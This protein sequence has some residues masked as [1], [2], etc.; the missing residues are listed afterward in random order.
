M[1]VLRCS[2]IFLT[3]LLFTVVLNS[4]NGD[5]GL[6]K[7][8]CSIVVAKSLDV[9]HY[10]TRNSGPTRR[11]TR[12]ALLPPS[13]KCMAGL[14][15]AN[16]TL[17]ATYFV[18]LA[19][20]IQQNP[21]PA[22]NYPCSLGRS[23]ETCAVPTV[24]CGLCAKTVRKNQSR[25]SCTSCLKI[26]HLRCY[27]SDFSESLCNLCY[28]SNSDGQDKSDQMRPEVLQ[29]YIPDLNEFSSRKGLK[30]L[31]Q[32]IRGLLTNKHSICQILD[33]LKNLHI[34]SLSET[35]LSADDEVQAQI[36]GYAY[37]G[38]ARTSGQGGGVG[39]YIPSSVP[40][41]RRTDL[42]ADDIECI[43]IEILFPKTKSFLIGIIYRPPDS[44][45]HLCA[46]FN[47][48]FESMLST[49]SSEDKECILTGDINCNYLVPADHKEIKSIL[50]S[51][52]LKQLI[53]T[54]TRIT[55]ESKTLI[56]I[57]CSNEP[58]KINHV[59]VIPAGL[60]DHELICCSR[61]VNNVKHHPRIITCRNFANY[62]AKLFCEELN[63]MNF[64]QV[65]SS[66]CVN[67][68]WNV[69]KNILQQCIDKHAPLIEKK[70]KGRLCPWLTQEVKRE[71]NLRD[72]LLR[73][74]RRTNCELDWSSYK[75]QRNRVTGLI[76]KCKSKYHQDILRDSADSPDKFWCAIKKLYPTKLPSEQGSA[77]QI[78]G[79]KSTDK[80]FISNGFC[81]FFTNA[82]INL[83]RKSFLLRDFVWCKNGTKPPLSKEKFIFRAVKEADI[84][85]ELKKLKRKKATGLDNLS[86][87]LLKDAAE[88]ITKPL[89]FIINLSLAT[90]V[91]PTDWKVAKVIPLFKSGSTAEIDNYRPISILPTLSKIL[92]RVVYKQVM[93]HLE[94]NGLISEHQFG[95]RS[96]RSTELAVTLFTDLIRKEADG[97]KA[98]G[99]VFIDLTKAFDTISHSVLLEK[100]SCYGIQD[101]ELN[102][103]TDYLFLRK[104]LVQFKGVL[105]EPNPV[106]T[107][108]P[109]GSILGPLLFLIHFND[110]HQPLRYSKIITYADDT[111][112]FTSSKD[113]DAI[114]HNLG[115]D[116]KSLADWFRDNELVINLK[117]G[118][119]EVMLFGTAKR[120]NCFDGKE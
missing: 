111:V 86:P 73:K 117:K 65:F 115:E 90:G 10:P 13:L 114:Q 11:F 42:E 92:E 32:N 34:L 17:S 85:R 55:R 109:Q 91:V 96:N 22:K 39:V 80:K 36:E 99:A 21:G 84:L 45:K 29:Q 59:K 67:T 28:L 8:V 101:N 61:K 38:K 110:V 98:T 50:A 4:P 3:W 68:A 63:S 14:K 113:L 25:A 76:K 52:G 69:L 48:K 58:E 112:I 100:L 82:A 116:I 64:V 71:M 26:F 47:C 18:L 103:F 74:A 5:S 79:T 44:S 57:I 89:T 70:V 56:D 23:N 72:G 46:D 12:F 53:S 15:L 51:V 37:I 102:W 54:P 60:S 7:K 87:G 106:F 16:V 19:G 30:I 104:Q 120:L 31:H 93:T 94:R 107:G 41:Q 66:S 97:G 81:D 78:N 118:K 62:D 9:K 105:S 95:F 77:F 27:G 83:K 6:D 119:T 49:V 33:G 1:A 75:R 108:V 35:H 88:V 24:K 43:W 20:D 40:Y 2:V